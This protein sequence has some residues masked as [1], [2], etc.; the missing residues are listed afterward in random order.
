MCI[1]LLS[2]YCVLYICCLLRVAAPQATDEMYDY[3]VVIP[4]KPN[5]AY[6][7][8]QVDEVPPV[9]IDNIA[10]STVLPLRAVINNV[11]C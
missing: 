2:A 5:T 11:D 4:T 9:L 8:L 1:V 6:S 7:T 3:P 10:Y